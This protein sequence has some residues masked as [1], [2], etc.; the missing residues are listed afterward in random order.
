MIYSLDNLIKSVAAQLGGAFPYTPVFDSPTQ[1]ASGF[2]CFFV[3]LRPSN[4][5]DQLSARDLRDIA[6]DVIYVQ[7]RNAAGANAELYCIAEQLD[8]ILDMVRYTDGSAEDPVPL[9]THDRE[10]SIEDQELHYGFR[11]TQRVSR[12]VDHLPMQTEETSVQIKD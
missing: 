11:V 1:Q 9:H 6:L 7:Q 8:E 2:P 10:Y 12:P 5:K 3:F 4:I